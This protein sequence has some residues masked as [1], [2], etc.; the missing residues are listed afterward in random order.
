M[1]TKTWCN[2]VHPGSDAGAEGQ[3]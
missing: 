3:R 2:V 1:A